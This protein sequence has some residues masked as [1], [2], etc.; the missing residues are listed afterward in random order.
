MAASLA[1]LLQFGF[2]PPQNLEFSALVDFI[3]PFGAHRL[4][5][6]RLGNF[7]NQE[8]GGDR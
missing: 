8:L 3:A 6:G 5:L 4:A 2:E 1:W 7:I